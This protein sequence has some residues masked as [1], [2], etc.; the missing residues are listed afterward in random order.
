MLLD[1]HHSCLGVQYHR[2]NITDIE[3]NEL[4]DDSGTFR[5]SSLV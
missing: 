5:A 3:R 4:V 2:Q 1:V